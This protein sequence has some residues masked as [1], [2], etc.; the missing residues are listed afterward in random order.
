[1]LPYLAIVSNAA[2]N[3]GVHVSLQIS[4]SSFKKFLFNS[5]VRMLFRKTITN[6]RTDQ[7]NFR[8]LPLKRPQEGKVESGAAILNFNPLKYFAF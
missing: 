5:S 3:I 8:Q 4:I 7:K 6:T 2:M 1:M